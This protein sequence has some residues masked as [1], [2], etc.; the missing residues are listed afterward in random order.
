MNKKTQ[1][2]EACLMC[3]EDKNCIRIIQWWRI[4]R[5][6]KWDYNNPIPISECLEFIKWK[7][8]VSLEANRKTQPL[9][10]I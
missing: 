8:K 7:I 1:R 9:N 5:T 10:R 3:W 2:I 4:E 6:P